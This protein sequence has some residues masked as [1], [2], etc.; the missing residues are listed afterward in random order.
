MTEELFYVPVKED[1]GYKWE[2]ISH[3]D[4]YETWAYRKKWK[5][6]Y[7]RLNILITL[8][9]IELSLKQLDSYIEQENIEGIICFLTY[10]DSKISLVNS[11][12]KESLKLNIKYFNDLM[13]LKNHEIDQTLYKYPNLFHWL[14][15]DDINNL[16]K[17]MLWYVIW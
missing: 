2:D 5:K 8:E 7:H 14:S 1:V 15:E 11:E 17:R 6:P 16:H 3:V 4:E 13:D 9:S 12:E 10:L